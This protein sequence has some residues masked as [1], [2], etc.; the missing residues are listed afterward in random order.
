MKNNMTPEFTKE[1]AALTVQL[2]REKSVQIGAPDS[3]KTLQTAESVLKKCE[4][5]L[6]DSGKEKEG[7]G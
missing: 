4:A 6:E 1:E 7:K 5:I 3:V 2:L